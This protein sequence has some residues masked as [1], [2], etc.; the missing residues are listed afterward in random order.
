[1]CMWEKT[2][3]PNHILIASSLNNLAILHAQLGQYA[4]AESLCRRALGIRENLF[5]ADHLSITNE[6][7][8]L[9]V[10]CQNQG[11]FEDVVTA[12]R[13]ALQI[14]SKQHEPPS[15]VIRKAKNDLASVLLKLENI[16][17]AESLLKAVLTPDQYN[18][19]S[20][21]QQRNHQEN[22]SLS[23]SESVDQDPIA[24]HSLSQ[25]SISDREVDT[26]SVSPCNGD[27]TKPPS[28]M[29]SSGQQVVEPLWVIVEQYVKDTDSINPQFSLV[30]WASEAKIELSIVHNA[31]QNLSIVYQRQGFHSHASLLQEWLHED[32]I[33]ETN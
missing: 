23:H 15:P 6:L 2:L 30:T 21:Q 19:S 11:K 20:L 8:N 25:L 33:T 24:I 18:H 16:T 29:N 1:M 4:E 32:G 26:G 14:Y 9:I 7:S 13:R 27:S 31:V 5:G 12:Y 10:L 22:N 17:E 3:G 28:R